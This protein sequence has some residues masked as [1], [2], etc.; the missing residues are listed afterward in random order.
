MHA[1]LRSTPAGI[2]ASY[3]WLSKFRYRKR[4]RDDR[5]S[6]EN[7]ESEVQTRRGVQ[8]Q[9]WT[10]VNK[11]LQT[12]VLLTRTFLLIELL[13]TLSRVRS[14][15]Y[16]ASSRVKFGVQTGSVL[17]R[18][19][20]TF[21]EWL[22]GALGVVLIDWGKLLHILFYGFVGWFRWQIG[23]IILTLWGKKFKTIVGRICIQRTTGLGSQNLV[24][25]SF[26]IFSR[27]P[28]NRLF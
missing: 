4:R 24:W 11:A 18:E 12:S 13:A 20:S 17:G 1:S 6:G 2:H 25:W 10:E 27:F 28:F 14:L 9:R 3:S 23:F 15:E 19:A 5:D 21:V 16:G 8:S 22:G 26:S 7:K